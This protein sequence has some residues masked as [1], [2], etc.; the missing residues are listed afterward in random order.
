MTTRVTEGARRESFF[1]LG[2]PPSFLAS[3]GF[4]AQRSRARALS[5][6]N[7]RKRETARSLIEIYVNKREKKIENSK[8][9][10]FKYLSYYFWGVSLSVCTESRESEYV[11]V[12]SLQ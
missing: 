5:S 8:M 7:L 9:R 4:A 12:V 11:L 1:L 3:R 10:C 2:L 6:L